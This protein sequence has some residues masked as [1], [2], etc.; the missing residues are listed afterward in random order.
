[1]IRAPTKAN[2]GRVKPA[3]KP[4][5]PPVIITIDAPTEAPEAIPIIYGSAIGF[6]KI[7]CIIVPATARAIPTSAPIITLG[8]RSSQI[9]VFDIL[10]SS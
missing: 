4:I 9:M 1:M 3:R 6:R 8:N 2:T 10:A 5:V 7:A